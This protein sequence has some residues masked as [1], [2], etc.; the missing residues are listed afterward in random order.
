MTKPKVLLL[1]V[2]SLPNIQ[3]GYDLWNGSKPAMIIKERAIVTF[4]YK[5]LGEKQTKVITS[6]D[7]QPITKSG[8]NPYNDKRLVE[9]IGKIINQADYVVAHYGDK[10]DMRII[11]ARTLINGL[12]SIAPVPTM[13][14]Y[15]LAKKYFNLNANRLDYLGKLLGFGGKLH[16]GWELW[17]S[18]AEG[19]L[20]ALDKMARYNKRDVDLLEKVFLKLLPHTQSNLNYKLFSDR[21]GCP[22]CGSTKLQKRGTIV[23]R[24]TKRIR[25]HCQDC[26]SWSSVKMEKE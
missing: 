24:L 25:M 20:K 6:A 13:D 21:A 14:T 16:T 5:W 3:Y 4:A 11:R 8:W 10:F 12:P 23:N 18:C 17:Q 26:G 15:K 2:E 7:Y 19:D 1:D 22:H 9:E